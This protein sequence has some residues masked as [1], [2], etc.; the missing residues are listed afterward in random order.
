MAESQGSSESGAVDNGGNQPQQFGGW[1]MLKTIAIQMLFF[2]MITSFFRSGNNTPPTG[3]DGAPIQPAVNIFQEG[4]QMELSIYLT[5]IEGE[6]LVLNSAQLLWS[7]NLEYGNWEDGPLKDGCRSSQ[8]TI[9]VP[10]SVQDNG[11]WYLHV[12]LVKSGKAIDTDSKEYDDNALVHEIKLFNKYKKRRVHRTANLI[13]GES[14]IAP[15]S[16]KV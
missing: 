14:D 3:P 13:T 4:Q 16:I 9:P 1:Q 11:S 15:G 7:V 8:V 10:Q 12:L 2:Y 5:D 6:E